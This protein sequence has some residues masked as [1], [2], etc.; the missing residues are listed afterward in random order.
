MLVRITNQYDEDIKN[1]SDDMQ[2]IMEVIYIVA[3][4]N[5]GL[6]MMRIGEQLDEFEDRVT[7]L[8]NAIQQLYHRRLAIDLLTLEQMTILHQ[9]KKRLKTDLMHLPLKYQRINK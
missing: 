3:D 4:Y 8:V 7:V 5:P 9:F 6:L 1:L 2:A